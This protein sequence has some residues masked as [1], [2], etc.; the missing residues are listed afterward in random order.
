MAQSLWVFARIPCITMHVVDS[1]FT[2]YFVV[3]LLHDDLRGIHRSIAEASLH[4]VQT[5]AERT[6]LAAIGAEEALA[7]NATLALG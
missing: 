1:Y 5:A 7:D 3:F 6:L 2:M 4:D